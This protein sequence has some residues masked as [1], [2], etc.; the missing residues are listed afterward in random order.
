MWNIPMIPQQG[1]Q[2]PSC[3]RVYSPTQ[4]MCLYCPATP[5]TTTTTKIVD[6]GCVRGA[7]FTCQSS[8]CIRKFPPTLTTVS[9]GAPRAD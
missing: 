8:A 1:W 9:A 4:P 3:A 7:E 5:A 2:C 6:C